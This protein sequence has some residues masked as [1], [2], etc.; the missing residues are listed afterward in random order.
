MVNDMFRPPQVLSI[1]LDSQCCMQSTG[2]KLQLQSGSTEDDGSPLPTPLLSEFK[3]PNCDK[4]FTIEVMRLVG[5]DEALPLLFWLLVMTP[6][7]TIGDTPEG[8]TVTGDASIGATVIEPWLAFAVDTGCF[9]GTELETPGAPTS[10]LELL[11][12]LELLPL[13]PP[14][15]ELLPLA[16]PLLEL[17]VP[18]TPDA[19]TVGQSVTGGPTPSDPVFTGGI[20]VGSR[21]A[22]T[23]T[24]LP[25]PN[26]AGDD[27]DDDDD[28]DD[29]DND[30]GD[31]SAGDASA[32]STRLVV[33]VAVATV[34]GDTAATVVLVVPLVGCHKSHMSQ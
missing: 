28:D 17:L 18:L 32:P 11:E 16:P 2:V 30:N 7:L 26:T 14:L 31:V 10:G 12:L 29:G 9:P 4:V 20:A 1:K 25:F 3:P 27:N 34:E 23:A 22:V 8:G 24:A 19:V 33:V 15:L 13:A 21:V 6:G 5:C